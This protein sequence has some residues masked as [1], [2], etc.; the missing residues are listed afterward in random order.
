MFDDLVID[1]NTA[2]QGR[3]IWD[4]PHHIRE[5][6]IDK[7]HH[8]HC[9]EKWRLGEE[10]DKDELRIHCISLIELFEFDSEG[11]VIGFLV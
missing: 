9:L 2:V 5:Q 6:M 4:L 7:H 1:P 8:A 11:N 3:C 10:F